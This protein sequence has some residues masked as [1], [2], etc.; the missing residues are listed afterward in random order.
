MLA[1]DRSYDVI[2]CD[3][4]MPQVTGM[5]VYA[6]VMKFDPALAGKMIF[7]TG[8]A[9]TETARQFLD[10]L[11]SGRHIEK[12]FDLKSLRALINDKIT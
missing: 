8:G 7:V 5:D 12:P 4:M 9:F 2:V 6:A 11:E 10:T 3:L 1:R